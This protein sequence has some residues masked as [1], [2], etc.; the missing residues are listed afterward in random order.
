VQTL[1]EIKKA[2][3][4]DCFDKVKVGADAMLGEAGAGLALMEDVIAE[5]I[6]AMGAEAVGA[7]DALLEQTVEYTR[8]REQ[9]GQPIGK[10]QAL[11]HRMAEMVL[12]CQALRCLA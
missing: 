6:V 4:T 5:A 1:T 2:L 12:Q 11:Q 9:F 3:N 7:M 10:F 8:T